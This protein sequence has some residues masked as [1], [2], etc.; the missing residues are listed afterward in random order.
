MINSYEFYDYTTGS[1]AFYRISFENKGDSPLICMEIETDSDEIYRNLYNT[2]PLVVEPYYKLYFTFNEI[3]RFFSYLIESSSRYLAQARSFIHGSYIIDENIELRESKSYNLSLMTDDRKLRR[4]DNRNTSRLFMTIT[5]KSGEELIT[6]RLKKTRI[7]FM[8]VYIK[9]L[10]DS[11][12]RKLSFSYTDLRGDRGKMIRLEES[13]AIGRSILNAREIEKLQDYLERIIFDFKQKLG[14]VNELFNYRQI[15]TRLNEKYNNAVTVQFTEYDDEHNI[16][17]NDDGYK[18]ITIFLMDGYTIAM[19]Y[20]LLP[21]NLTK[22]FKTIELE[23]ID[24]EKIYY[25]N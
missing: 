5:T 19:L 3:I 20:A 17:I 12:M 13:V 11:H 9:T 6:L 21:M 18:N 25:E 16:V 1:N 8:L 15:T 7:M 2:H 24:E 22:V 10:I 4:N 23:S 14:E